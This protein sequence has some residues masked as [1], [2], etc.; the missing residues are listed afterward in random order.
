M[1]QDPQN[2]SFLGWNLIIL[3]IFGIAVFGYLIVMVRK[4]WK[5]GYTHRSGKPP[6]QK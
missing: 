1:Q 6:Q 4:R 2:V 5:S 3:G